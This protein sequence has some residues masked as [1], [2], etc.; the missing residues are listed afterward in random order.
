ME[1]TLKELDFALKL[2]S[3]LHV[4]GDAVDVVAAAKNSL[5]VVC[6][7]IQKLGEAQSGDDTPEK[8]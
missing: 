6:A 3:S 1:D 2:I 4:S 7:D 5:R 8:G